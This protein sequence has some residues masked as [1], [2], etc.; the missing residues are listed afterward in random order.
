MILI[1]IFDAEQKYL[2]IMKN[3]ILQ[4]IKIVQFPS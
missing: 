4:L 2:N 3:K 1:F